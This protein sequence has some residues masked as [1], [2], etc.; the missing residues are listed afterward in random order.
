MSDLRI[1]TFTANPS[2]DRTAEVAELQ[3]GAVIRAGQT[4]VDGGG[5]G[6]NVTR[7]LAANGYP[8]VAVLPSGGAEGAQLLALLEA[9]RLEVRPVAIADA[10]RANVTIVEPDG[11]T[12]KINEPGPTLTD[13]E[14]EALTGELLRVAAG[15]QWTV[16]SGSLPPG[17]P[18]DLYATLTG[19]LHAAGTRVAVDTNGTA[20]RTSLHAHPDLI[21]PNRKELSEASGIEVE[22]IPDALLAIEIVR[23]NGARTVLASLGSDGALLVE[24]GGAYHA[25]ASVLVP[26]STVGAGD[27][28]L[29]GFLARGG[30]GPD[31][32]REA[33][34]WG[35]AAVSLPGSRMPAPADL[36][37]SAVRINQLEV[38][39]VG[40]EHADHA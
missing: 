40:S 3:R 9:E 36:D 34:A 27:A 16:L 20:L 15:A 30:F 7:A 8:S 35:S 24:D 23:N 32:L 17:V 14:I 38:L 2:V 22:T 11:T 10:V 29:A 6:V 19:R 1:V 25:T 21:K 13:K 33:V 28:A 31:A 37:R 18:S 26:R 4:R 39:E 5:K 12:T